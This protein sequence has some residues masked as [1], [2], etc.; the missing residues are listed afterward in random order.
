MATIVFLTVDGGGNV[1]PALEIARVLQQRGNRIRFLG[2]EAQRTAIT[3]HGFAFR[4]YRHGTDWSAR[5]TR[6]F[7][8][9]VTA[10]A[11]L[12]AARGPGLDLADALADE[13]ADV[14]V[15]DGMIP[16]ALEAAATLGVPA[17]ALL[18]TFAEFFLARPL[19]L[20][21]RVR[22]FSPRALWSAAPLVIVATD[23]ELDP[24]HDSAPPN[25][26]WTGVAEP[27]PT[28]A[29]VPQTPPRV[30]VSLSTNFVPGQAQ[31]LQTVLDA[32]SNLPASVTVTT[33]SSINPATLRLGENTRAIEFAPHA[34][35]L[36][37][38]SLVVSHGGH[39]TTM[40]SLM[41]NVPLLVMPMSPIDQ[42]MIGRA[43][44]S[45]GA[46]LT[47]SKAAPVGEIRSAIAT[48]L[49]EPGFGER[50]AEIGARLRGRNGPAV[51]ADAILSLLG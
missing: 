36:P 15:V 13:P 46:G 21:G 9:T 49:D 27:L 6:S 7:A 47:L 42:P 11:G 34:E 1:P 17:V 3:A 51:A 35:L 43:V 19:E 24:A 26:R 14:V 4:A 23:A 29:L 33:G 32:A 37:T 45:A 8:G 2:A 38:M 18:H 44:E 41:H 20:F 5:V 50:A 28:A 22:G 10:F 25:F 48:L 30:L 16:R 40:R 39:S 12:V 31:H